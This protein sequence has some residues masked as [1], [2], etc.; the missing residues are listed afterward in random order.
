MEYV[1]NTKVACDDDRGM[2]VVTDINDVLIAMQESL[3]QH[4]KQVF[5][6]FQLLMENH[7]CVEID[8]CIFD[9]N[10]IP[11]LG[12]IVSESG[13]QMDPNKAKAIVNWPWATNVRGS[14]LAEYM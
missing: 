5:N 13:L 3:E 4:H 7:I 2:V 8:T 9:T 10:D 1:I 6:V 11:F 14:P 12:F